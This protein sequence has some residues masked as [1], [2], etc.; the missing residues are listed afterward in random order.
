MVFFAIDISTQ[1][2]LTGAPLGRGTATGGL[3]GG[4]GR[5]GLT[6]MGLR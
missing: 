1:N 3:E 2:Y 5:S 6:T 4:N